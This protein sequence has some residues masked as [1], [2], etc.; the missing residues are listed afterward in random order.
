METNLKDTR[1][2]SGPARCEGVAID[3]T[4]GAVRAHT[5]MMALHADHR[6]MPE[7]EGRT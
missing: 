5:T 1:G 7:G 3:A 4:P 2:W 6:A